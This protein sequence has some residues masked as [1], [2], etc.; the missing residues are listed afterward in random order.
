MIFSEIQVNSERDDNIMFMNNLG[1]FIPLMQTMVTDRLGEVSQ[2]LWK[3]D[4]YKALAQQSTELFQKIKERLDKED[5]DMFAQYSD[6]EGLKLA[7]EAEETY[8]MGLRDGLALAELISNP[9]NKTLYRMVEE[10][11]K[12]EE[13]VS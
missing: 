11:E 4:H 9:D 5:L 7:Q 3:C 1:G 13:N 12:E 8:L 2:V 10:K 6:V